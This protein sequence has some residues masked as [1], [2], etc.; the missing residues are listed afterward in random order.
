MPAAPPRWQSSQR[1]LFVRTVWVNGIRHAILSA[2]DPLLQ[3]VPLTSSSRP[4]TTS[5]RSS[6]KSSPSIINFGR[7]RIEGCLVN[8]RLAKNTVPSDGVY[9][10]EDNGDDDYINEAVYR[11]RNNNKDDADNNCFDNDSSDNDAQLLPKLRQFI[12]PLSF[13]EHDKSADTSEDAMLP[14][15]QNPLSERVL[16]W[17]DLSGKSKQLHMPAIVTASESGSEPATQKRDAQQLQLPNPTEPRRPYSV[18]KKY[19]PPRSLSVD[20]SRNT[21]HNDSQKSRQQAAD[22]K[23]SANCET[24][25]VKAPY[26][27]QPVVQTYETKLRPVTAWPQTSSPPNRP[28]LH[29]F[30]PPVDQYGDIS[31]HDSITSDVSK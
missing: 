5:S 9:L 6:T 10:Q 17:L 18:R 13:Y 11:I 21:K 15:L 19:I 31:E 16:Q 22:N 3:Y 28:Q 14:E 8:L 27:P 20:I 29:I 12:R 30:M 26:S 25:T 1:P 7:Y 4:S 23:Q 24:C 2:D